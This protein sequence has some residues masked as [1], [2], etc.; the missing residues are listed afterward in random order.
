VI[1]LEREMETTDGSLIL[2]IKEMQLFYNRLIVLADYEIAPEFSDL[3]FNL[4]RAPWLLLKQQNSI[5]REKPKPLMMEA[6]LY[7]RANKNIAE[8]Y[9]FYEYR[10]GNLSKPLDLEEDLTFFLYYT[11]LTK[12]VQKEVAV[13]P[14]KQF[15]INI[16]GIG[17]YKG[18]LSKPKKSDEDP[19]IIVLKGETSPD[20]FEHG[21]I[22]QAELIS[23][24]GEEDS[25]ILSARIVHNE[26]KTISDTSYQYVHKYE[27]DNDEFWNGEI[28][29][30]VR[31]ISMPIR[32]NSDAETPYIEINI[33]N[34][35]SYRGK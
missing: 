6:D 8:G 31:E 13:T 4:N 32:P 16:S 15:E 21:F 33:D 23:K 24:R 2:K 3:G 20:Q 19:D 34:N 10:Y 22:T 9:F 27:I 12:R 1:E 25:D 17:R 14:G 29:V 11:D 5:V 18:E 30:Q 35:Q 26:R 28:M 7:S